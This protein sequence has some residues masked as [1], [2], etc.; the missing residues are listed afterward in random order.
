ML[1]N[2]TEEQSASVEKQPDHDNSIEDSEYLSFVDVAV[3]N[4]EP[5]GQQI[6]A[7]EHTANSDN[8]STCSSDSDGTVN[9]S[10][11]E[12]NSDESGNAD[13]NNNEET[14]HD[15]VVEETDDADTLDEEVLGEQTHRPTRVRKLPDRY[16]EWV[17]SCL[18]N[19]ALPTLKGLDTSRKEAIKRLK[20]KLFDGRSTVN[21]ETSK[22]ELKS[23]L[24]SLLRLLSI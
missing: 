15:P 12:D 3:P 24:F 14:E 23:S 7:H 5:S 11:S 13:T 4:P 8:N 17:L 2:L 6:V 18:R 19:D 10:D 20:P 9:D 16:G 1:D 21:Q 22:A